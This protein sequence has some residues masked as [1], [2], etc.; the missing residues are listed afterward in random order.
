[1]GVVV[2]I[3]FKTHQKVCEAGIPLW[4]ILKANPMYGE[5]LWNFSKIEER[6]SSDLFIRNKAL[7]PPATTKTSQILLLVASVC[8]GEP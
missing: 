5:R 7:T 3:T 1:M 2:V 4:Y 6:F 8:L